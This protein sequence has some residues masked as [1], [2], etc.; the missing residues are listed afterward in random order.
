ML[1]VILAWL[2]WCAWL[3]LY[4]SKF[5]RLLSV[6]EMALL[7]ILGFLMNARGS[8]SYT[9]I[10]K[11]LLLL[12]GILSFYVCHEMLRKL[13]LLKLTYVKK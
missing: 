5:M 8:N 9:F 3:L 12:F 2:L 6:L 10:V 4:T 11:L 13:I 1:D 7:K